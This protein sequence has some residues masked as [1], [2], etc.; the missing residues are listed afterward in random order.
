MRKRAFRCI[1]TKHGKLYEAIVP[2]E[3]IQKSR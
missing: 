1:I 2:L 3:D